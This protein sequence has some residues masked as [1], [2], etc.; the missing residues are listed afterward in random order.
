[1]DTFL[2]EDVHYEVKFLKACL[3][4]TS[5]SFLFL[6]FILLIYFILIIA[7]ILKNSS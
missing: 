1:M 3:Q 4:R 5:T 6:F 2:F 7:G